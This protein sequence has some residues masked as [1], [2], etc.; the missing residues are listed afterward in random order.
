MTP[1]EYQPGDPAPDTGAY[2][3]LN[4]FGRPTGKLAVVAKDEKLPATARGF[5]W[6]PLSEHSVAELRARAAEYHRMADAPATAFVGDRLRSLAERFDALA[7]QK[8]QEEPG[9]A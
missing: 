3:E 9:Q 6:R 4:V 1:R 7:D 5:T 8:E 2:E